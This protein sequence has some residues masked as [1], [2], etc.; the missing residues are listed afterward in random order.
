MN[1]AV[2]PAK[3]KSSR[4]VGKNL[5]KVNG[6][7]LLWWTVYYARSNGLIH[8]VYVSTEDD[9]IRS[10]C[11]SMHVDVIDRPLELCG[12]SPLLDV[13]THA[14]YHLSTTRCI[15]VGNLIGLQV[16]NPDRTLRLDDELLKMDRKGY[17][18]MFSISSDGEPNG[19]AKIYS[20]YIL[21]CGRPYSIG[22]MVDDCTNI[23][24]AVDLDGIEARLERTWW[25]NASNDR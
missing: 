22:V 12:E 24:Y 3:G 16:D 2:I 7:S 6:K 20:R 23:H 1:V 9:D 19:A 13:Y 15:E 8:N 5:Y 10:E 17:N 4:F 14:Y 11:R 25:Y 18:L 21:T